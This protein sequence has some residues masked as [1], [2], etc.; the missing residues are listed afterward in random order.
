M[1]R[2]II[3]SAT[4]TLITLAGPSWA[5]TISAEG[6][7]GIQAA[8]AEDVRLYLSAFKE[9]IGY[10]WAGEPQVIPAGDHYDVTLPALTITMGKT[11]KA[12]LDMGVIRF[13]LVPKPDALYAVDA[14]LPSR[15]ILRDGD[16]PT[17]APTATLTIGSQHFTGLWSSAAQTFLTA[18]MLWDDVA[19]DSVK[20]KEDSALRIASLTMKIALQP[21]GPT[22]LN[23]PFTV[24]LRNLKL[25]DPQTKTVLT[26]GEASIDNDFRRFNVTEE[27]RFRDVIKATQSATGALPPPSQYLPLFS[28]MFGDV[29]YTARISAL[30]VD[31]GKGGGSVDK[32]SLSLGVRDLDR[33]ASTLTLGFTGDGLKFTSFPGP[34]QFMPERF[35]AQLVFDKLPNA[36]LGQTFLEIAT[37]EEQM[38][39]QGK[40]EDDMIKAQE[41]LGE[42]RRNTLLDAVGQAGTELR[43]ERLTL[44]TPATSGSATGAVQVKP[45]A[46]FKAAGGAEIV[47]RGLDAAAAAL[48]GS[49][50]DQ[51]AVGMISMLQMLGQQGKNAEG[52]EVRTYKI[53]LTEAGQIML[54]GA[55]MGAMM[56]LGNTAPDED[57][58]EEDEGVRQPEPIKN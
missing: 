48:K 28:K 36:T 29:S 47:L 14:T 19:L 23:G 11:K 54:N 16:A 53:D 5:Q 12:Q 55:D 43:I 1:R 32:A 40:S 38:K 51:Q 2:S 7:A 56:G 10:H 24:A 33:E 49:K 15:M 22:L 6:A 31:S 44:D 35:D 52:K 20:D 50:G 45:Q 42:T 57:D 58:E 13:T 41:A 30:S 26:V 3:A 25:T 17:A 34:K 46:A 39:A 4:L 18:D 37:L 8:I 21:D 9:P 27:R